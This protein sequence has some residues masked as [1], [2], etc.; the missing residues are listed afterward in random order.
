MAVMPTME[1]AGLVAVAWAHASISAFL[2]RGVQREVMQGLS[3]QTILAMTCCA[4]LTVTKKL[5]FPITADLIYLTPIRE[6]AE[7]YPETAGWIVDTVL[8]ICCMR[9]FLQQ[10]VSA[11]SAL[12][13]KELN[14]D[15]GRRQTRS[16]W[17]TMSG[18]HERPPPTYLHW[19]IIYITAAFLAFL[20]AW[21][22][23]RFESSALCKW[24]AEQPT[25]MIAIF[26][27]FLR[28]V[29]L[30]PQLHMSHRTGHVAP[31]LA[32]WIA[33]IGSVDMIEF[34]NDLVSDGF[35]LSDACYCIGDAVTFLLV[36][37]FLWLFIKSRARGRTLVEM[38]MVDL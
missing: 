34:I 2:L 14:D 5:Y 32:I 8:L 17:F 36:S 15:F 27:N 16:L 33:M 30:L 23:A 4:V 3:G 20:S 26:V 19:S 22:Q 6:D 9:L 13:D 37:D 31:G 11:K 25:A 28:G 38:P 24:A 21:G 12:N 29:A 18:H 7:W 10:R 35:A 1:D